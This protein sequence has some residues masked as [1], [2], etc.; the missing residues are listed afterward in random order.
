M[1]E[2]TFKANGQVL[3]GN[4]CGLGEDQSEDQSEDQNGEKIYCTIKVFYEFFI[5]GDMYKA[6]KCNKVYT[7]F[8]VKDGKEV[9]VT[10]NGRMVLIKKT[11]NGLIASDYSDLHCTIPMHTCHVMKHG[12]YLSLSIDGEIREVLCNNKHLE[13]LL[14]HFNKDFEL[15]IYLSMGPDENT[16]CVSLM[17]GNEKTLVSTATDVFALRKSTEGY[18]FEFVPIKPRVRFSDKDEVRLI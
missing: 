12:S 2:L 14:D 15:S 10:F 5:K 7:V 16:L 1:T 9:R 3:S 17:R 13:M 8:H 4:I 6:Y 18:C 11:S